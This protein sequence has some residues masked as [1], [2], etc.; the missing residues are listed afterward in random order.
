MQ[1][2]REAPAEEELLEAAFLVVDVALVVVCMCWFVGGG[3]GG[4]VVFVSVW[5]GWARVEDT[6]PTAH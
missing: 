1:L 2:A 6:L 5:F 3:A 4:G